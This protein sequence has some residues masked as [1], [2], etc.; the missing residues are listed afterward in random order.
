MPDDPAARYITSQAPDPHVQSPQAF[1]VARR[2]LASCTESHKA[3]STDEPSLLPTR[4]LDVT[5][6]NQNASLALYSHPGKRAQYVTL[7]YCWGAPQPLMTTT[8][9]FQR[10]MD[11]IDES[12]LP[13][14]IQDAVKVTRELGFR[15]LWVDSLCILQDSEAD[16]THEIARMRDVYRCSSLTIQAAAAPNANAGFLER[17]EFETISYSLPYVCP[18]GVGGC[19]SIQLWTG[20]SDYDFENEPVNDRAW[21]FQETLLSPRVLVFPSSPHPLLWRCQSKH[22]SNGGPPLN[23]EGTALERLPP[24]IFN[25]SHSSADAMPDEESLWRLWVRV[26]E[27]YTR[28]S[29]TDP[30]D[31]Q[32]AAAGVAE[33]F[34]RVLKDKYLAGLWER[35]LLPGLMWRPFPL[36]IPLPAARGPRPY[37]G[38]SWSWTSS[39]EHVIHT[40]LRLPVERHPHFRILSCTVEGQDDASSFAGPISGSL[41]ARAYLKPATCLGRRQSLVDADGTEVGKAYPDMDPNVEQENLAQRVLC[42]PITDVKIYRPRLNHVYHGLLLVPDSGLSYTRFGLFG[43]EHLDFFDDCEEQDVQIV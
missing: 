6:I 41:L 32:R 8:G 27:D 12:S 16:K 3:C 31:K 2:W 28:R 11:R 43:L 29:L 4:V 40:Y 24:S 42:M 35:H 1:A 5:P 30:K 23:I 13:R 36:N 14:S 22:C 26:L 10:Y 19:M 20:T 34:H 25:T 18:D 33:Q 38:P 21:I 17:A 9:N 7:S 39:K 15:Y 37:T